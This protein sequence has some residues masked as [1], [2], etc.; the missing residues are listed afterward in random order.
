MVLGTH[1]PPPPLIQFSLRWNSIAASLGTSECIFFLSNDN[2]LKP[3][4][5]F[6]ESVVRW[7]LQHIHL[8]ILRCPSLERF[9]RPKAFDRYGELHLH[10]PAPSTFCCIR[11]LILMINPFGHSRINS[12]VDVSCTGGVVPGGMTVGGRDRSHLAL[13]P[14]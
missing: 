12:A 8:T 11:I 14:G 7:I 3:R 10:F 9:R 2:H 5:F 6:K 13:L 4:R 1:P